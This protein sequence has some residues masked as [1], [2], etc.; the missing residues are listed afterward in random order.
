MQDNKE[1]KLKNNLSRIL[2]QEDITLN[3]E[4]IK[5][6]TTELQISLFDCASALS[7]LVQS[8]LSV[9]KKK[10]EKQPKNNVS[11]DCPF[12][13]SK[14]KFVRYRIEIG[15]MHK[16]LENEIKTLLVDVS[17]VEDKQIGRM[18]IRNHY[19]L[20][21]L[22]DGMPADIFQLLSETEIRD[23][24]LKLKRI[25]FQRRFQRRIDKK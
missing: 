4:L 17:G 25:K 13:K 22:P 14:R 23:R 7:F 18:E 2:M 19:T 8:E 12:V 10:E 16:V 3:Q 6:L 5:R 20:V 21:D 15:T 9:D 1:E 11:S 24:K